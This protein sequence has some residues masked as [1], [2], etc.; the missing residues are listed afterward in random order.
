MS[1]QGHILPDDPS[2]MRYWDHSRTVRGWWIRVFWG[3]TF[4]SAR[5]RYR[6]FNGHRLVAVR[7]R[8]TRLAGIQWRRAHGS[9][10]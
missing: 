1:R 3:G 2:G 8:G 9:R 10:R 6:R 4:R 7:L 5:V